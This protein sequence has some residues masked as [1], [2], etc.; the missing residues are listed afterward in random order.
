MS[1]ISCLFDT[2]S[3]GGFDRA[4]TTLYGEQNLP[5]QRERWCRLLE[6]YNELFADSDTPRLFSAPG[7]TEISGNHT[8]HQRG[9]VVAA[10]I[11]LDM[12]A[13]AAKN[14]CNCVRIKSEGFDFQQVDLSDLS[15]HPDEVNTTPA[16]IRGIAAIF[17]EKGYASG[18]VD[19][20][21]SS[22]VLRGSGLS[23]S[24]AFEVLIGT[25]FSCLYN[26]NALSPVLIAQIGQQ[27]ENRY[28]GK[29]C[30]LM[31]EMAC[32]V[33]GFVSIDFYD[34]Q[35]PI[36][37][38]SELDLA[39]LGYSMYIVDV[40]G[41]HS[42]LTAEYAAIPAE[43]KSV[44]AYFGKEYLR[45]LPA[46]IFYENLAEVRQH[47]SDRAVIRAHHFF[48][49]NLR[50]QEIS[51]ALKEKDVERFLKLF[52]LS[53][54]SSFVFL[55]NIYPSFSPLSQPASVA[56]MAADHLLGGRGAC[57][58]HGGGFGGTIQVFVPNDMAQQFCTEMEKITGE[59]SCHLLSIRPCGG[60][61]LM[62]NQQ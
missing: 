42:D 24:A 38:R 61:E 28:F 19:L 51:Q 47:T 12:I 62:Q 29:P 17:R 45:Q 7:R 46:E 59:H 58:I 57:R 43:M 30:G 60:I 5:H 41:D 11:N 8:D 55:Q 10:S 22:E 50:A 2:I 13:A 3:S 40:K 37:E 4:M 54:R 20:C 48:T 44:A 27:A 31:D 18:G 6:Q 52:S 16:L 21:V 35:H 9:C 33:G 32:S 56:L 34:P 26:D 36:V 49:E 25:V 53:G 14:D 1:N 39:A 23:S 15:V